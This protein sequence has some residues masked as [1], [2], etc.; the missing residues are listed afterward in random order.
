MGE[1]WRELAGRYRRLKI[2][3]RVLEAILVGI[4]G[5]LIGGIVTMLLFCHS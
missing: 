5:S 1:Y 2:V 4:T 3:K